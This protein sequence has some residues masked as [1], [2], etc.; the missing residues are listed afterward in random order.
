[1]VNLC[2]HF[3]LKANALIQELFTLYLVVQDFCFEG[4]KSWSTCHC[5]QLSYISE[6]ATDI[7]NVASKTDVVTHA[8][9]RIDNL[10]LYYA[11]FATN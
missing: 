10:R 3:I 11:H 8:L 9:A 2:R 4:S 1:M 6:F 5:W 7:L